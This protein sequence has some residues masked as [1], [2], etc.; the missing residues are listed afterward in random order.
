MVD[1]LATAIIVTSLL[2]AAV[3]GV[4][5]LRGHPPRVGQLAGLVV[6]ELVLLA[7]AVTA[8]GRMF[9]GDRPDQ[10]ATF[11]GYLLTALLIPPL[12]ALLGWSERTRWGSVIVAVACLVVPVMVV[13]LQQVWHG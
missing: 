9:T 3:S 11:V 10:L 5:A 13:R 2:V 4:M 7:Q 1:G 6:V 12:A 8:T